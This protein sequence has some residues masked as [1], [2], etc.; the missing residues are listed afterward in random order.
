MW[1]D[2]RNR[3][4]CCLLRKQLPLI[5]TSRQPIRFVRSSKMVVRLRWEGFFAGTS[6]TNQ[7]DC[8]YCCWNIK[9]T[10]EYCSISKKRKLKSDSL[11]SFL[12]LLEG[13]ALVKGGFL[14]CY[15]WRLLH[16]LLRKGK[17]RFPLSSPAI[18]LYLRIFCSTPILQAIFLELECLR[19]K[20][21]TSK[22]PGLWIFFWEIPGISASFLKSPPDLGKVSRKFQIFQ[23]IPG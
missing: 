14:R 12:H 6:R 5:K 18:R 10:R 2:F 7:P 1:V 20:F 21:P 9:E 13:M 4:T 23:V 22:F 11:L 16:G 3:Y 17:R 19:F 8:W 15:H